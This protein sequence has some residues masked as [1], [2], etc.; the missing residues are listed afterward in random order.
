MSY[1]QTSQIKRQQGFTLIE[2]V[3]AIGIFGLIGLSATFILNGILTANE[4]SQRHGKE[5]AS[6][7]RG[8]LF[9]RR[10]FEQIVQRPIMDEYGTE[11]SAVIG[12]ET[13]VEFTRTGWSN[14][15]PDH[16]RRSELQRLRY[17]LEEGALIREYWFELDRASN[18]APRRAVLLK[19]VNR[20]VVRYFD[21]KSQDWMPSWPPIDPARK[22]DLPEVIEVLI[23]GK[24]LGE[25]RR[26]Y[27]ITGGGS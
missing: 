13:G 21:K 25:L 17:A 18:T 16:H 5:M 1:R 23:E 19:G 10:D 26:L 3:I 11:Q 2:L 22:N 15:L 6:L 20:F 4:T 24:N 8:F 27:S 9:I 7:Q 14:P 12:Y